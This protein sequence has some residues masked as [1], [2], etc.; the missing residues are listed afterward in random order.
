ML[1]V[2]SRQGDNV[3]ICD[4]VVITVLAVEDDSV[5]LGVTAPRAFPV[6]LTDAASQDGTCEHS[7]C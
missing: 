2:A 7:S 4:D 6:E 5:R 3:V 1:F